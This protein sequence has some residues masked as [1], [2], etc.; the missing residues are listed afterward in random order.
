MNMLRF[1][2]LVLTLTATACAG[3]QERDDPVA[4]APA[5]AAKISLVPP[6]RPSGIAPTEEATGKVSEADEPM[7]P[8]ALPV[9]SLEG[10][11]TLQSIAGEPVSIAQPVTLTIGPDR[12]DFENC[13]LVSWNYT[14]KGGNVRTDRTPAITIDINP[15]PVPCAARFPPPL[16][17]MVAVID[18]AR[19]ANAAEVG[20]VRLYGNDTYLTLISQ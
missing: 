13:Q 6:A 12:I 18:G 3:E 15:K 1:S 4:P 11:W 9:R 10:V 16:A 8:P 19:Q 7:P 17:Q 20:A 2:L 14:L 5:K